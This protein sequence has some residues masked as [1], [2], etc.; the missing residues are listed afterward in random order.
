MIF[1]FLSGKL[2]YFFFFLCDYSNKLPKMFCSLCGGEC[3]ST[4]NF[5]HH[6]GQQ[7]KLSHV[8]NKAASSVYKEK[9]LK[10]HFHG[11]FPYAALIMCTSECGSRYF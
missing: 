9:L 11:E 3:P 2:L 5:C 10:K 1:I 6:C 4:E 7:L 8:S